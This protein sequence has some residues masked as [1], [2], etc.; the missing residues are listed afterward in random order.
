MSSPRYWREIPQ[1]YRY[2]AAKCTGCG[3]KFFPPRLVCDSCGERSFET[4]HLAEEGKVLTYTVIHIPPTA[5]ADQAPYAVAVV[6]LDD[7]MRLL[8]QITDCDFDKLAVGDRVRMTFR[9]IQEE[10]ESGILCYGYKCVP[11]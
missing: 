4:T 8:T 6:E 5:F 7:E 2:E 10:G 1:R 11:A 3:K 9:K